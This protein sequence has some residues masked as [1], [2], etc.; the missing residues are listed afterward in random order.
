MPAKINYQGY[1]K[2]SGV[3]MNSPPAVNMEFKLFD[4]ASGGAQL[5]TSGVQS[6]TV[7]KGRFNYVI[8]SAGCDL[9]TIDWQGTNVYLEIVVAGSVLTPR[10]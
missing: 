6:I 10:R 4:A 7:T 9:T 1:V 3:P 2:Q 8:G 5:C